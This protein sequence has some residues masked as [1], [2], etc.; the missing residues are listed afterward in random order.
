MNAEWLEVRHQ[1]P[2]WENAALG[3]EEAFR[4]VDCV[5]QRQKLRYEEMSGKEKQ[6]QH[7]SEVVTSQ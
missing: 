3:E 4:H 7:F 6:R 1:I 5:T 2:T